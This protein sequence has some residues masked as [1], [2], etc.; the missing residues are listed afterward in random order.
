MNE[1]KATRYRRAQRTTFWSRA[2]LFAVAMIVLL[3]GGGAVFVREL[4]VRLTGLSATSPLTA[5]LLALS[6]AAIGEILAVP[7]TW[8]GAVL[9]RRYGSAANSSKSASFDRVKNAAVTA[10][11]I[12]GGTLVIYFNLSRWPQ[13]WWAIT[14]AMGIGGRALIGLL[15]NTSAEAI[16]KCKP[17]GRSELRNRLEALARRAGVHSFAVFEWTPEGGRGRANARLVGAGGACSVLLSSN[18]VTDFT[19]DE[20]EVIV[21]HELG[22]HVHRDI[23]STSLLRAGLTFLIGGGAA[24][25]LNALWR[26]LGLVA[27]NDAA[28]LPILLLAAA[29]ATMVTQPLVNV[30]SRRKEFR[31]DRFA[32]RL[33]GRP[34]VLVSVIRRLAERHLAE[35]RPS[36][37]TVWMFHSHPTVDQRIHAVRALHV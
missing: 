16:F 28:G 11:L 18:L 7:I 8:Y 5:V 3:P 15:A 9:E 13:W 21:A 24:A 36:L 33:T 23:R 27:P 22:H 35:A 10:A 34:D 25:A 29:V 32:L 4:L 30:E 19:P 31:A 2:A 17:L 1:D 37:A 12:A 20:L 26:P 6:L 14:A